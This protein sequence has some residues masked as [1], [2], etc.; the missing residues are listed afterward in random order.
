MHT[1]LCMNLLY[2]SNFNVETAGLLAGQ[3]GSASV[4]ATDMRK[5]DDSPD[6]EYLIELREY[7]VRSN[8][9]TYICGGACASRHEGLYMF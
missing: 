9:W 8:S 3:S 1:P 4:T 7:E 6:S 2:K 5:K